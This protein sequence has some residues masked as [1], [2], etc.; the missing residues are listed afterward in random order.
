[1]FNRIFN[2]P[3]TH[4]FF[5]FG[6]RGCGKST[7]LRTLFGTSEKV[8]WFDLLDPQLEDR[9]ATVPEEFKN[10]ILARGKALEWVIVDEVQKCPKLLNYVHQLIEENH[11]KFAL[12]GSSA[13]RLKQKGVNLLAGRAF[14]RNLF[15]LTHVELEKHFSLDQALQWGSLPE[16]Y[17]LNTE[18]EK[19]DY[20]RAYTLYYVKNEIQNEQWVRKLDP[21]RRF[22]PIAAQMNTEI[23]NYSNI[24][25]DIGVDV[26]TIQSYY[27]ILEDTLLGFELPSYSKSV[28]KQQRK[29]SKFYFFDTG[30]VQALKKSLD[31]PL[32]PGTSEYGKSFEHWIILEIQRLGT[33]AQKDISLSYL[34]T[35]DD[36]EIDLIIE[37]LR[38]NTV[39]IEIKSKKKVDERDVA[40]LS[41]F[42]KDFPDGEF[43]IF[44]QDPTAKMYH[45]KIKALHWKD[46]IE[47]LSASASRFQRQP[48]NWY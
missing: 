31:F 8:L 42:L 28:R 29:A 9:F 32:Q 18:A 33:Y 22:L 10:E 12:T 45:N 48:L 37:G 3:K 41:H 1:M 36:A 19:K 26:T 47:E 2:L 16:I 7:L 17:S 30:V 21:F 43:Y 15:P 5:L 35:K 14:I 13:R 39:F 44:S 11:L 38:K 6:P 46:G 25:K 34:R 24:A 23:I 4:S 27:K 40:T 20:L